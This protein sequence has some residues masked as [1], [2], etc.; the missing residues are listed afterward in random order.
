VPLAREHEHAAL[1]GKATDLL[2]IP[3]HRRRQRPPG[4]P[5]RRPLEALVAAKPGH[6]K[7]PGFGATEN[8]MTGVEHENRI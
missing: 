2:K 7:V 4:L 6:L 1:G 3:P 8:R 5:H